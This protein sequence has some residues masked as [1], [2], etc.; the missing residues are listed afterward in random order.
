MLVLATQR[1]AAARF[2]SSEIYNKEL[3]RDPVVPAVKVAAT[4]PLSFGF[5][6]RW[7]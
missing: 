7:N 3:D 5:V 4:F 6:A 1:H 2:V